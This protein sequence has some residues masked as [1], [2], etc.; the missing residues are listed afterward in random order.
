MLHTRFVY[1][2]MFYEEWTDQWAAKR[3]ERV[4]DESGY[5]SRLA[6]TRPPQSAQ[7]PQPRH[8]PWPELSS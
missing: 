3:F 6:P 5:L 7:P 2:V 8:W 4:R 1:K